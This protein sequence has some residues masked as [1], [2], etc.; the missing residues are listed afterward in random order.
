MAALRRGMATGSRAQERKRAAMAKLRVAANQNKGEGPP[1]Q[2]FSALLR[3][4]YKKTHPDLLRSRCSTSADHNDKMWQTVNGVLST[5]KENA[6]PPAI[7][8]DIKLFLAGPG[9]PGTPLE[10]VET[11]IHTAGGDCKRSLTRSFSALFVSAKLFKLDQGQE[12]LF[13]WD[14]EYFRLDT[15]ASAQSENSK[16][17]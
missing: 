10:S 8:Q 1:G 16:D 9:Q 5:V 3:Q 4:L 11:R 2:S 12:P 15:A 13:A 14:G 6:Y 17:A 7:N